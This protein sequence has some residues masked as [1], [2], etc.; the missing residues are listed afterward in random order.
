MNYLQYGLGAVGEGLVECA[1]EQ[2]APTPAAVV[3]KNP[4]KTRK[5]ALLV[6]TDALID[7]FDGMV[8]TTDD[9]DSAL[10]RTRDALRAGKWVV[11]ANKKMIAERF[12][13]WFDAALGSPAPFLYEA[14]C[15]AAIPVIRLLDGYY[16]HEHIDHLGGIFNGT[17][18]FILTRIFERGWDYARALEE[19]RRLG[20][21]ESDPTLDVNGTDAA[22][23]LCIL[24]V[25]AFGLYVS[26]SEIARYGIP[27]IS[28]YDVRVARERGKTIK[29]M[30]GARRSTDGGV[31]LTVLPTFVGPES[32]F[33]SVSEEFNAVGL[34]A[35]HTGPAFWLGKGAG[36]RPTGGALLADLRAAYA[37][38][39]YAYAKFR[40][41][42]APQ[43]DPHALQTVYVRFRAAE[44]PDF[45]RFV[46][47]PIR[48]QEPGNI[49]YYVGKMTIQELGR[50]IEVL[51]GRPEYFIAG[52]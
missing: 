43:A 49:G 3:V 10:R 21:A 18:N 17:T 39:R 19:A 15:C 20:F 44:A 24:A 38:Q 23:K 35:R 27:T 31:A 28:D 4:L 48:H 33:F 25:H 45:V 5:H 29:L 52:W 42:Q 11:S 47:E 7:D 34:T 32:P 14:S 51:E 13:D 46:E 1:L 12:L 22:H 37:G 2:N 9:A 8:E 26:P 50:C 40:S 41:G 16:A 36:G 30:A 6:A